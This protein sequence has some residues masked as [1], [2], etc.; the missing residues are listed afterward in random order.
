VGLVLLHHFW[1]FTE[2]SVRARLGESAAA[3]VRFGSFH[4]RYFPPG[5]VIDDVVFQRGNSGPWLISI[6]R[7][8]ITSNIV[9]LMH[10]HITLIHAEG[11]H[12]TIGRSDFSANKSSGSKTIIDKFVADDAVLD[13]RRKA[14]PVRFV[15]HKLQ[16]QNL[17]GG[18]DPIKFAAVF[19]NPMPAGLI[20]TSGQ[21]GPW[22]SSDTA[23]TPVSGSYALS[24]GMSLF[25]AMCDIDKVPGPTAR[26]NKVPSRQSEDTEEEASA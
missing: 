7:L 9:G 13:V 1:P 4:E 22:N 16:L 6:R 20:Q 21:F 25:Q 8:K 26:A 18:S 24:N 15:F 14:Q 17:G 5:C 10:Q 11:I 19:D 3:T 23:D 12:A 2:S